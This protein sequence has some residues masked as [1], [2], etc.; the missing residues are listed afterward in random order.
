MNIEGIKK[1]ISF[2][3]ENTGDYERTHSAEDDL[4]RDF[5]EYLSKTSK[6]KKIKEMAELILSTQDIHFERY[7]A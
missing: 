4:Y 1:R 3:K 7:C 5:I 6:N 2:I